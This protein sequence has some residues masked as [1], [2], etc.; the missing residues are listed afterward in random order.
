MNEDGKYCNLYS[1]MFGRLYRTHHEFIKDNKVSVEEE[2]N[3][4]RKCGC[5][6]CRQL[7]E[8]K[9]KEYKGDIPVIKYPTMIGMDMSSE[10]NKIEEPKNI[11]HKLLVDKLK[12]EQSD[13]LKINS[14]IDAHSSKLKEW[15]KQKTTRNKSI[16]ELSDA[17][18]KLGYKEIK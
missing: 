5:I 12:I 16:K 18:K 17:L 1:Q 13:L 3:L 14:A 6:S 4:Y 8:V 11:A 9:Y 15:N 10:Q 7:Y 2:L